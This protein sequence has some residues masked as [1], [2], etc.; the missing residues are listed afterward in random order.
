MV[1]LHQVAAAAVVV[2]IM[3]STLLST[4]NASGDEHCDILREKC[5]ARNCNN[6]QCKHWYGEHHFESVFCKKTP[7]FPDQCCC[8]FKEN[9]PPPPG[10][11]P[12]PSSHHPSPVT[13]I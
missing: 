4:T 8:V 7:P 9:T 5:N 3:S 11:H 2:V 13:P 6:L 12:S 1:T 10:H